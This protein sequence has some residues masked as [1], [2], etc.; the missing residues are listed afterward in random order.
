MQTCE[1][2]CHACK[3]KGCA[4][5]VECHML[6]Q[7][8][9]ACSHRPIHIATDDSK[10]GCCFQAMPW[11]GLEPLLKGR[12]YNGPNFH[13]RGRCLGCQDLDSGVPR[14]VMHHRCNL[15]LPKRTRQMLP[16]CP[17]ICDADLSLTTLG[18]RSH[19]ISGALASH[20]HLWHKS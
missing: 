19:L 7:S 13:P 4:W 9:V 5:W 11:R 2:R 12:A 14:H 20:S 8:P 15:I 3:G 1:S 6:S 17:S 18:T 10:K 16:N